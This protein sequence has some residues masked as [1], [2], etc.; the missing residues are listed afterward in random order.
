MGIETALLA[1][2]VAGTGASLYGQNAARKDAK[3][4]NKKN[5]KDAILSEIMSIVS[6]Q[7]PQGINPQQQVVPQVDYGGAMNQLAM[8]GYGVHR[9][10]VTDQRNA[11]NDARNTA[12]AEAQMSA[13]T[14][15]AN[16]ANA[17]S[18]ETMF[19]PISNRSSLPSTPAVKPP[20]LEQAPITYEQLKAIDPQIMTADQLELLRKYKALEQAGSLEGIGPYPGGFPG[21]Q[22]PAP[23]A[24]SWINS[25]G[26]SSIQQ[27]NAPRAF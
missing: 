7:G 9:D 19:G 14:A 3:Q 6:G 21:G 26:P 18:Y 24:G 10:N 23:A 25:Y 5:R 2:A 12:L 15:T 11:A 8:M 22:S 13:D 4:Q 27:T 17:R 16:L 1:T 20:A